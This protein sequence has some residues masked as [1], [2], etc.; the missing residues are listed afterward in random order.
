MPSGTPAKAL[1]Y[2]NLSHNSTVVKPKGYAHTTTPRHRITSRSAFQTR[3]RGYSFNDEVMH[4]GPP[5]LGGAVVLMSTKEPF[6]AI[7]IS[8]TDFYVLI[9][10]RVRPLKMVTLYMEARYVRVSL[11][12]SGVS[13]GN[14]PPTG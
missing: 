4:R 12:F 2:P 11:T 1:L 10:D 6:A 5:P 7:S 8:G 13:R 14:I 9:D 3:K